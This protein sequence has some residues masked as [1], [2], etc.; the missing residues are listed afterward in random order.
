MID[1]RKIVSLFIERDEAAIKHTKDIYGK[2]LLRSAYEITGD[3]HTAE[4]CENDTYL[5]AWESIPPHKPYDYFYAFLSH[6]NRNTALNH[7]R[8]RNA[9]KRKASVEELNAELEQVIPSAENIE[10]VIDDTT[11]KSLLDDFI[12]SLST[13]QRNIFIRRYWY[14]DSIETI[15]EGFGF[16]KSKVKTTLFRCR[17]QLKKLLEK[18]GYTV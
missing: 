16:S 3:V 14:L 9:K 17:N 18:E 10:D 11:L 2:R 5:K 12:S 8:G 7:C 15:A 4:E 13:E 6:I 1:D